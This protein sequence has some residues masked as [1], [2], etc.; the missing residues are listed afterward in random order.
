MMKNNNHKRDAIE[1]YRLLCNVI[2]NYS[3]DN[4]KSISITSN[5]DTEG[6]T[7]IAKNLAMGLAKSG[8]KTLF[9]DC[10]LAVKKRSKSVDTSKVV[11]LIGM[12]ET[13]D[14]EKNELIN[15]TSINDM[16]L[17]KYIIESQYENLA[18]LALGVNSLDNYDLVFKRE[19]L[20]IIMEHVKKYYDYIIVDAPSFINLS[21]TQIVSAATDGCLFVLKE[22]VNEIS[23]GDKIKDEIA[24]IECKML[25]CILNTSNDRNKGFINVEYKGRRGRA[26]ISQ[27]VNE[28]L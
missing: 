26:K 3:K 18:T 28:G 10:S 2:E 17:K 27:N 6:K 16:Q 19:Y 15:G 8:K 5:N 11:G 13:I 23:E 24:S 1:R 9:V 14:R 12:L 22:G 25:G 21:Y 20:K 7:I 4:V